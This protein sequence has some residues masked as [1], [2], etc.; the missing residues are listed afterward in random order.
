MAIPGSLGMRTL[1]AA[2]ALA[3][4]STSV[5]EAGGRHPRAVEHCISPSQVDLNVEYDV[6][7]AIVTG[8]GTEIEAGQRWRSVVR[9]VVDHTYEVL[10]AGFVPRGV[11]PLDDFVKHDHERLA[12]DISKIA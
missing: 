10:P 4:L 9:R 12:L 5:A 1:L 8:F 7:E 6:R 2:L 11:T 3:T